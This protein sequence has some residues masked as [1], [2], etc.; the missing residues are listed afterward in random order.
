MSSQAQARAKAAYDFYVEIKEKIKTSPNGI[1]SLTFDELNELY[2]TVL[3][4]EKDISFATSLAECE[5]TARAATELCVTHKINRLISDY[6]AAHGVDIRGELYE[7]KSPTGTVYFKAETDKPA[8][9]YRLGDSVTFHVMLRD[10]KTNKTASCDTLEY[11]YEIEGV[12]GAK[13]GISD[14]KS[15]MLTLTIPSEEILSSSF[16]KNGKSKGIMIRLAVKANGVEY[17]EKFLGG[18]VIDMENFRMDAKKPADF[19]EYWRRNLAACLAVSPID[20]TPTPYTSDGMVISPV[21]KKGNVFSLIEGNTI[22]ED[23][24]FRVIKIDKARFDYYHRKGMNLT[25]GEATLQNYDCYEVYLK[26]LGACPSSLML[27]IPKTAGDNRL[28]ICFDGYSAHAPALYVGVGDI[29][30]HVSHHGYW[31]DASDAELY[32]SLNHGDNA[33][34][35][36]YGKANGEPNS[37]YKYPDD[38]YILYMFLRDF[39]ALRFF[40]E[41]PNGKYGD[42]FADEALAEIYTN[43]RRAWNGNIIIEGVSMGG[44]QSIGT[45]ALA[46]MSGIKIDEVKPMIP[47]FC[48]LSGREV[49]GRL[50]TIFGMRYDPCMPYID[51]VPLAEYIEADTEITR[52]SLG[53]YTCPPAGVIAAY[54]A[55]KCKKK[56]HIYQNSTHGYVPNDT[57]I[58][59][60]SNE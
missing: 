27:S 23:N 35:Y 28:H 46:A 9:T 60:V 12:E 52:C 30:V 29:C 13:S 2:N 24:C 3:K 32:N 18:A 14:G 15:G 34:L 47:G 5:N 8:H 20:T 44:Y 17:Q 50:D 26:S 59:T 25:Q 37:D 7:I 4:A 53:D 41:L 57:S 22:S 42:S 10:K 54:N 40:T 21:R 58:Y 36:S 6:S 39:Q 48:N 45:A 33:I 11:T 19:D 49:G 31:V 51:A 55:L 56:M 16:V 43:L 38:N 1:N